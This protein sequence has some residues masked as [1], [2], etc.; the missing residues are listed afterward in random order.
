MV[1]PCC[2]LILTL[3]HSVTSLWHFP[4]LCTL[5]G[6]PRSKGSCFPASPVILMVCGSGCL[7]LSNH[8]MTHEAFLRPWPWSRLQWLYKHCVSSSYLNLTFSIQRQKWNPRGNCRHQQMVWSFSAWRL[9]LSFWDKQGVVL[10]SVPT[11]L[12]V[13]L[14]TLQRTI[15]LTLLLYALQEDRDTGLCLVVLSAEHPF[16]IA[17]IRTL[18]CSFCTLV[19]LKVKGASYINSQIE[20]GF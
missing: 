3:S 6:K 10:Q 7:W 8:T 18:Q 13:L 1:D 17:T 9:K 15:W 19:F 20:P 4:N 14:G 11:D 2:V 16:G 12:P 5:E